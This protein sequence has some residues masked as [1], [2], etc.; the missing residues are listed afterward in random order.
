MSN[1]GYISLGGNYPHP[2]HHKKNTTKLLLIGF[3]IVLIIVLYTSF[4]GT[5]QILG[6]TI[7]GV[8]NNTQTSENRIRISADLTIPEL[9]T[10]G[11][12][13]EIIITAQPASSF[14]IANE[15]ISI[16]GT[17][18][19]TILIKGYDG[20]VDVSRDSI[21]IDGKAERVFTEDIPIS[22]KSRDYVK[23][24]VGENL[25]YSSL[26]VKRDFTF[27]TLEYLASG[28]ITLDQGTTLSINQEKIKLEGFFGSMK[29]S[30]GRLTLDGKL[31]AITVDGDKKISVS[32]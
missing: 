2:D 10:K 25:R 13:N 26:E 5:P 20:K 32:S 1:Q 4:L 6:N 19:S 28:T 22:S 17:E 31:S 30:E 11:E 18:K 7:L 14:Y 29:I 8:G 9:S 24:E 23:I 21:G 16:P 27:K 15:E 3:I 12:F